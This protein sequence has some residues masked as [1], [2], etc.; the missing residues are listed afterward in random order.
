MY[1]EKNRLM[2]SVLTPNSIETRGMWSLAQKENVFLCD[3]CKSPLMYVR[4][5]HGVVE[6]EFAFPNLDGKEKYFAL[7]VIGLALYCAECGT[8]QDDFYKYFYPEDKLV[9]SWDDDDLGLADLEEIQYC[10][11]QFNNTGDFKATHESKEI[12]YLKEKLKEYIKNNPK[13]ESKKK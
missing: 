10:L 11:Q 13:K 4:Q 5:E 12:R 1:Q 7:R 6:E 9:C 2:K 8:F 3:E